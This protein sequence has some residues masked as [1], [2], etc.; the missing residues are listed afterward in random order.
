MICIIDY[1][2]GNLFSL[3]SSLA[4]LGLEAK[5]S[6]DAADIRAADRLILPGVGAFGDA[7]AKLEATGL[8]PVIKE[9][10][11]KKPLL[12]ICL[13]MQM[14]NTYFLVAE[15]AERRGWDGP[16][17]ALFEQMKKERY[18]F[19][20]PV[21]GHW[22]GHIT[23]DNVDRFKHPIHVTPGSRLERLTGK[24]TILGASMHNYRITHP[25]RSLTVAGR[26]DDGT[27]EALEYGEQMLGVQFHPEADDQNDELF[28]AIL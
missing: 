3:K 1:G 19:T 6:A 24:Q 4:H 5:V 20:E 16:L 17:L 13:G 8:V 12:G 28:R 14:M 9:E 2:V 10:A 21:D 18:M 23:R 25:A 27:I 7:M 26:T 15:E 11:A 22:D